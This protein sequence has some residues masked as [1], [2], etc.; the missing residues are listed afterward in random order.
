ME[1]PDPPDIA[2]CEPILCVRCEGAQLDEPVQLPDADPCPFGRLRSRVSLHQPYSS[3]AA[4]GRRWS[5]PC[6]TRIAR[7]PPLC[8]R[9][10]MPALPTGIVTFLF[11]DIEGS[12]ELVRALGE[13]YPAVLARHSELLRGAVSGQGG[14]EFGTEGDALF[15]VFVS[16][17]AAVRAA[18]DAQRALIAEPWPDD[19]PVRVRIGIHTGEGHLGGHDYVGIDVHRAARVASAGHGGQI[20][21]SD[22]T[23]AL[24]EQALPDGVSLQ[25][26]GTYR[27]KGLASPER[28]HQASVEGLP[29][30]FPPLHSLELRPNNLPADLTS[31]IGRDRQ[32]REVSD[33]MAGTRLLTLTG[34]GGTGKTRLAIRIAEELIGEYSQGT[35]FVPLEALRDPDLVPP[36]IA[37]ALG[38]TVP[39]DRPALDALETWLAERELLL[40]LDNCEQVTAAG[41]GVLR[42]LAAAPGLRVL[43]TSRIPFHVHG[44]HEYPVPPLMT[45]PEGPALT[46]ERLS[47]YEAVRLFIE[48]AM[49]VKP[50]FEV[51]NANAPAV[52]QIC[53]RLDGLPLAIELAAARIKLLG[54]EQILARL[55][56]NLSLLSSAAQDLP[57]RQRTLRGAIAWSHQLLDGWE[58]TLFA[59]MSIFRGGCTLGSAEIVCGGDGLDGD[60][61]EGVASLVDKSLLRSEEVGGETRL[62]M[63]ETIR[64][65]AR[66]RLE[67]AGDFQALAQRHASL[68]LGWAGDAERH[69]M[70]PQQLD[71]LERLS[72]DHDNLRAAFERAPQLGQ[73]DEALVAAGAMW[74][75]WQLRGHFAEARTVFDRLLGQ[76]GGSPAARAKALIGAGGIAYWQ[77]DYET[78]ARDYREA[79]R[80]YESVADER[81]IAE[82]LYNECYVALIVD[83]DPQTARVLAERSLELYERS[84]DL[85]GVAWTDR[86]LGM[87]HTTLGDTE[88]ALRYQTRAVEA[89]RVAGAPW[90]LSDSLIGLSWAESQVGAWTRAVEGIHESI[91]IAEELG[92]E[93]ELALGLEITAAWAGWLGDA[94][95]AALLK[96]KSD[97][98]KERLGAAAPTQL[99]RAEHLHER[100]RVDLGDRYEALHAEG[101][102]LSV[103]QARTLVE[104]F[105][106]PPDAPP[107]P[108]SSPAASSA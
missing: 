81:G 70:G 2:L 78:M 55:D 85:L 45:L 65:Y 10:V 64:E 76:P 73:L 62:A 40:V 23:R 99:L 74:R 86:F 25:D 83:R 67:E 105:E 34:P 1:D 101:R 37:T 30:R 15:A 42:L 17:A 12:T 8:A 43:A 60:V 75:F 98:L 104:E 6:A 102:Q 58:Q 33:R 5:G 100:A 11:T 38:V 13:R 94:R 69:L 18:A 19:H 96:G 51:T 14:T 107:V 63:L 72:R 93:V 68:Y 44:E 28:I 50:E 95:R 84:D 4:S 24:V 41:P 77:H 103:A 89:T 80:L 22:A 57:E 53:A 21:L 31:F 26:L 46:A 3:G 108:Q 82:A 71:W 16:P 92:I 27:L 7:E 35:W 48:R 20:L 106:P 88:V 29:T 32:I 36:A 9:C 52:A 66:E 90:L 49:A 56:Q 61:F 47:Q 91:A 97:E 39:A 79:R 87:L 59:R 54:P